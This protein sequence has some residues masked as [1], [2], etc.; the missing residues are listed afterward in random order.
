MIR[1]DGPSDCHVWTN[2]Y[3]APANQ[4]VWDSREPGFLLL[5]VSSMRMQARS[6]K[7]LFLH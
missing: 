4:R 2:R 5:I 1:G 3:D 6:S 7:E